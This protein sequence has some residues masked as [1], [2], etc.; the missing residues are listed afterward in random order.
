M[1]EIEEEKDLEILFTSG[2]T[3]TIQGMPDIAHKCPNIA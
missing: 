3:N 1:I 2:S